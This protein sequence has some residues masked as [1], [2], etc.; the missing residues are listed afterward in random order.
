MN[1]TMR[2]R[3]VGSAVY[4]I[5]HVSVEYGYTVISPGGLVFWACD[6]DCLRR[7]LDDLEAEA[8]QAGEY[9]AD[10]ASGRRY[11]LS[12]RRPA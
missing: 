6:S 11:H 5:H 7:R 4:G 10:H 2:P 8:R 1:R 3:C 9:Q 12:P